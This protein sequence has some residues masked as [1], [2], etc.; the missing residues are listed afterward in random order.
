M[1]LKSLVR[2]LE[3]EINPLDQEQPCLRLSPEER[4]Q[5]IEFLINKAREQHNPL[6]EAP[7][8]PVQMRIDELLIKSGRE[9]IYSKQNRSPGGP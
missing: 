3:Q 2:K 8:T 6:S 9:P 4:K 7:V 1:S 5:R